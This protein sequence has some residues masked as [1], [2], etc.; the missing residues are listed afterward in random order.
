MRSCLIAVKALCNSEIQFH[1]L[2]QFSGMLE[3]WQ[4]TKLNLYTL[5]LGSCYILVQKTQRRC[6]CDQQKALVVAFDSANGIYAHASSVTV[7]VRF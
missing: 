1:N 4:S 3:T 5:P 7:T 2:L 6:I